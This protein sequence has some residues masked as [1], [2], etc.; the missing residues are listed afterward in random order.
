LFHLARLGTT[1]RACHIFLG[2]SPYL[3]QLIAWRTDG[4]HLQKYRTNAQ[5]LAQSQTIHVDAFCGDVFADNARSKIHRVQRFLVHQQQLALAAL[6]GGRNL[7]NRN[8]RLR[9]L[10]RFLP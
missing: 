3:F 9:L 6:F 2:A 5:L 7:Q 1:S 8:L 4:T 10:S